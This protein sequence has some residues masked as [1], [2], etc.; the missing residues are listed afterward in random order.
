MKKTIGLVEIS[1][2]NVGRKKI[3]FHH[4]LLLS[5]HDVLQM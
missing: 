2:P 3:F 4:Y 1:V 5:I